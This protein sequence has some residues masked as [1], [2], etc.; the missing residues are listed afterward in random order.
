[1]AKF[2]EVTETFNIGKNEYK[3]GRKLSFSD[4]LAD[5]YSKKLKP[6]KVPR[7]AASSEG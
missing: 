7:P 2:V 3:K 6:A 5:K 4:E 1:M